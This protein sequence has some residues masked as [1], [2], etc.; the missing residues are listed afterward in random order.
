MKIELEP[1]AYIE[2]NRDEIKD[3]HWGETISKITLTDSFPAES[4]KGLDEFSH[5]EIIF[6]FHHVQKNKIVRGGWHPR[7]NH[8]WPKTGIFSQRGKNRPNRIGLTIAKIIKLEGRILTLRGL[9]AINGT[10]VLDIKPVFQQFLPAELV[11]QPAWVDEL[12]GD[13]W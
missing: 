5:V 10:P 1:I 8:S 13:Y 11:R 2:N 12:M 3:D 4:L 9:D 7:N 6:C